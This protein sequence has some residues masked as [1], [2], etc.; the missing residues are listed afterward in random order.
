MMDFYGAVLEHN[1]DVYPC[2]N[3]E[4]SS[5]GNL[6]TSSFEE[7]WFGER[8]N[9]ARVRLRASCCPTCTSVCYPL[10]V[11]AKSP[12]YAGRNGAGA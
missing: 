8:A 9:E 10:P 4:H 12:K 11:N 1:G 6:L 3:C 5:F 2:I 7:V